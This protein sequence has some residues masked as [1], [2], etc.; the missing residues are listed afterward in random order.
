MIFHC[1]VQISYVYLNEIKVVVVV[2]TAR[3]N[4]LGGRVD[5]ICQQDQNIHVKPRTSKDISEKV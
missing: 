3:K 5:N 4:A 2:A 1:P